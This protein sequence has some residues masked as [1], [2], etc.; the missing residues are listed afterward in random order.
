[1]GE[2]SELAHVPSLWSAQVLGTEHELHADDHKDEYDKLIEEIEHDKNEK[3][4]KKEKSEHLV[5]KEK[6]EHDRVA[7]DK[8][9]AAL[10]D[11]DTSEDDDAHGDK[12]EERQESEEV[13]K[14]EKQCTFITRLGSPRG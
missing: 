6:S 3:K 7:Q 12:K 8:I 9:T 13:K 2:R 10:A 14:D 4:V 5:K 11:V 1:M